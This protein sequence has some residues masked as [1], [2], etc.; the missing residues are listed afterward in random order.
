MLV[1]KDSPARL[2]KVSIPKSPTHNKHPV[3]AENHVQR[4]KSKDKRDKRRNR[5]KSKDNR[6]YRES[7]ITERLDSHDE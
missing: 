2:G 4:L 7:D 1:R 3:H 5:S 6:H